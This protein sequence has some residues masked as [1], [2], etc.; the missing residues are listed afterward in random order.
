MGHVPY[1]V[2]LHEEASLVC[3]RETQYSTNFGR[4][5]CSSLRDRNKNKYALHLHISPTHSKL[6]VSGVLFD[7][8]VDVFALKLHNLFSKPNLAKKERVPT[9]YS[10]I[11]YSGFIP[12][13]RGGI[14][15][16]F[17]M[18]FP[19]LPW[20]TLYALP[21]QERERVEDLGGI[22]NESNIHGKFLPQEEDKSGRQWRKTTKSAHTSSLRAVLME[23]GGQPT[24]FSPCESDFFFAQMCREGKAV[25]RGKHLETEVLIS[26]QIANAAT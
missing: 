23:G 16:L 1:R 17:P 19:V 4:Q 25:S 20:A 26:N 22:F 15:F 21:I 3:S 5:H 9:L 10:I 6:P 12:Y 7:E 2:I 13:F 24:T 18:F 11:P 8:A 14:S